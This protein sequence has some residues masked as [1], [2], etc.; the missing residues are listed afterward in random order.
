MREHI[1][2]FNSLYPSFI[3]ACPTVRKTKL[4]YLNEVFCSAKFIWSPW[5]SKICTY[6]RG[7]KTLFLR[8]FLTFSF[9]LFSIVA[10]PCHC[11]VLFFDNG[12][13]ILKSEYIVVR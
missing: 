7:R 9:L 12:G 1:Y 11:L 4:R 6:F 3:L 10:T 8:L 5:D 2:V 13:R